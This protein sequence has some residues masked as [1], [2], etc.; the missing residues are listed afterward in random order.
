VVFAFVIVAIIC[1]EIPG[2]CNGLSLVTLPQCTNTVIMSEAGGAGIEVKMPAAVTTAAPEMLTPSLF[3]RANDV[4]G[5]RDAQG[6]Q[7]DG[8]MDGELVSRPIPTAS[9]AEP[10]PVVGMLAISLYAPP[11]N[12]QMYDRMGA[13]GTLDKFP[14]RPTPP[15]TRAIWGSLALNV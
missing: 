10:T 9:V 14:G 2:K 4:P 5:G 6:I 15:P 11:G 1:G 13:C 12:S 8:G 3:A 7:A